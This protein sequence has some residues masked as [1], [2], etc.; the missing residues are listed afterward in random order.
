M[1]KSKCHLRFFLGFAHQMIIMI[2]HY[3]I[4]CLHCLFDMAA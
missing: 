3:T 2:I 4:K 1:E